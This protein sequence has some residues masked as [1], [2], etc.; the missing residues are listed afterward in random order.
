[1]I[2][3]DQTNSNAKKDTTS[4]SDNFDD[5]LSGGGGRQRIN[6]MQGSRDFAATGSGASTTTS[7]GSLAEEGGTRKKGILGALDG[8]LKK[9]EPKE[10]KEVKTDPLSGGT[11]TEKPI[12]EEKPKENPSTDRNSLFEPLTLSKLVSF[13]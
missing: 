8:K 5:P 13:Q 1:M 3:S 7:S 9:K 4:S 6:A 12:I 10:V 11:N 2:P